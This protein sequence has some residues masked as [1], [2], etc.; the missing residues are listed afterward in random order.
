MQPQPS[1][2]GKLCEFQP[3]KH[4][5]FPGIKFN[6][7]EE[8]LLKEKGILSL[9]FA[10]FVSPFFLFLS[11]LFSLSCSHSLLSSFFLFFLGGEHPI[12]HLGPRNSR[13]PFPYYL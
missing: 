1:W 4:L 13:G 7:A 6:C 5:V 10:F 11:F 9:P 2:W 12:D 3:K 8:I